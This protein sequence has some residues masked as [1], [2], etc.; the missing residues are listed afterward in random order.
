MSKLEDVADQLTAKEWAIVET[1][2]GQ[3]MADL[4]D[5][6]APKTSLFIALAYVMGKRDG[7][8]ISYED[9]ENMTLPQLFERLG[10]NDDEDEEVTE[11]KGGKQKKELETKPASA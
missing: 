6:H 10:L 4:G 8:P 2:S 11:G 7:N 3:S 5:P 1:K 9:A